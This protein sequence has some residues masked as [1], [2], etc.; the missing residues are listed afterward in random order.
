MGYLVS[1]R[2]GGFDPLGML[3][4]YKRTRLEGW[5]R[6]EKLALKNFFIF[7]VGIRK[8][9]R[10]WSMWILLEGVESEM[11]CLRREAEG[12]SS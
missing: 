5:S 10:E 11:M 4:L 2:A 8:A 12:N 6:K 3:T 9:K 7:A 1:H